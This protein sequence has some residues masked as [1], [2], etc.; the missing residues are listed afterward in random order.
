MAYQ[1]R[2]ADVFAVDIHPAAHL[3]HDLLLDHVT[4]IIIDETTI[5]GHRIKQCEPVK[6]EPK[7]KKIPSATGEGAKGNPID[8]F[9]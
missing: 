8:I 6:D 1:S 9:L 5:I 2:M 4:G 3:D 7:V